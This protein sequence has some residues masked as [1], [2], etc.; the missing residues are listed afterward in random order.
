MTERCCQ[1]CR[2]DS[3][4][5]VRGRHSNIALRDMSLMVRNKKIWMKVVIECGKR[6]VEENFRVD[7]GCS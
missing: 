7:G 5:G 6:D 2:S 4:E 3:V 1:L